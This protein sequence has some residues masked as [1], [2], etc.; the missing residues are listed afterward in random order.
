MTPILSTV[1][2]VLLLLALGLAIG[3]PVLL[4][5][6][7]SAPVA[8]ATRVEEAPT[9]DGILD[10]ASWTGASRLGDFV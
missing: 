7:N 1:A 8:N 4:V 10:D 6:Q 5:A 2:R 9:I 3:A